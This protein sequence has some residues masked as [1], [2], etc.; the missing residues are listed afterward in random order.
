MSLHSSF[1]LHL[2]Y[3]NNHINLSVIVYFDTPKA[4]KPS[5]GTE[6]RKYD[7]IL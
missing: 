5:R 3:E 6:Q 2:Q 4:L 1:P 7:Q